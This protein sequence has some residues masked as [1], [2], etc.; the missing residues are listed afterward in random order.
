MSRESPEQGA[1]ERILPPNPDRKGEGGLRTRGFCKSGDRSGARA[2]SNMSD[3]GAGPVLVTVVT[4]VFNGAQT[5]ERT[6]QSVLAQ[7][8]KNVEFIVI[9]GGSVDSTVDILRQYDQAIDYW[10]SEP[11]SGIYD[12]W[13]KGVRLA[14]GDWIAFLGA[15]DLYRENALETLV[16]RTRT[17]PDGALEYVSGKALFVVPELGVERVIG[18]PWSWGLFQKYMTVAHVGSLHHRKFFEKYGLFDTRYR[19][20]GDYELLL[21]AGDALRAGF[22]DAVTVTMRGGGISNRSFRVFEESRRAKQL[23]GKRAPLVALLEK[24]IAIGKFLGRN[25]WYH[26]RSR[27]R[28]G[29]RAE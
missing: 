16:N 26:A 17:D 1:I 22:V 19:I 21:R 29:P 4:A 10:V 8:Y 5:L 7:S 6:I 14:S 9:D 25:A 24:Y 13:N 15:D 3:V 28:G 18:S 11:D 12:A 27:L 2:G 20:C 23:S